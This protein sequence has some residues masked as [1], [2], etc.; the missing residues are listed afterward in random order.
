MAEELCV[1]SKLALQEATMKPIYPL[2]GSIS[3]SHLAIAM[4]VPLSDY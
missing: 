2:Q 1:N 3:V 4:I